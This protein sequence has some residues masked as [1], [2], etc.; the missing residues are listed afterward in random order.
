[1]GRSRTGVELPDDVK[2]WLRI[3][4]G[5]PGFFGI[6]WAQKGCNMEDLWQ[7]WPEL[8]A[9]GWIPIRTR[10]TFWRRI[11]RWHT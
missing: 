2:A 6:G 8:P 4:N 11:P 5:A 1:M 10:S 7:L 9:K 3:T